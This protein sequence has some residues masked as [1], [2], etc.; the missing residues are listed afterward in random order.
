MVDKTYFQIKYRSLI[1]SYQHRIDALQMNRY[2]KYFGIRT[3]LK[4]TLS[5]IFKK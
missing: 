5:I 2:L 4:F 3:L 1:H